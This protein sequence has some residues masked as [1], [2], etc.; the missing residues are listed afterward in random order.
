MNNL[1]QKIEETNLEEIFEEFADS[2]KDKKTSI[3]VLEQI[4]ITKKQAQEGLTKRI[5]ISTADICQECKGEIKQGSK[6]KKCY[7]FGYTFSEKEIDIIIPPKIKENDV[8]IYKEKG[9]QLKV[10]EKR[11]DL[12]ISIHIFGSRSKRK[13]KKIYR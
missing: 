10:N 6:C 9:N 7:G 12:Y 5:A 1:F 11:G 3:N 2:I 4:K 13:G 8:I